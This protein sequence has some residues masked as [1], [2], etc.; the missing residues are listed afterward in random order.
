MNYWKEMYGTSSREFCE[1]VIAGLKALAIWH[2]GKQFVG[3]EAKPLAEAIQEARTRLGCKE[4]KRFEFCDG[5]PEEKYRPNCDKNFPCPY[6]EE[7][8]E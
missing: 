5:C 6:T 7:E 4:N 3:V 8:K 2:D 1:G